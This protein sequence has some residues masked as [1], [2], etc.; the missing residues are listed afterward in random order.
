M[1][2]QDPF[3]CLHPMYKVGD[4]LAEAVTAHEKVSK[5]VALD[6]SAELLV[7][8][9]DSE[10]AGAHEGLPASVLGRHAAASHDRH[11]AREQPRPSDRGRADD[12]ARRDRPGADHRA[13]RPG[14]DRV[15]H[16]RDPDHPRSGRDR[17]GGTEG[18]GHVRGPCD[19]S[20]P[21]RRDLRAAA[22]SLHLGSARVDA[23]CR[24][25]V[26]APRADRGFAAVAHL[27]STGLPVPSPLPSPSSRRATRSART[28]GTAVAATPRRV[29]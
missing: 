7:G 19:G 23:A 20:E 24:R 2:F 27:R 9:R 1:I 6:R 14:Q 5:K 8:C 26:E 22:S 17:R 4:Q 10:P 3:A 28:S 18:H 21:D 16:R 13:D 12:G 15:R 25:Q 11:G 29:T